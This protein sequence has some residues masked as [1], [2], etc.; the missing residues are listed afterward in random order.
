MALV[1]D[2]K[3]YKALPENKR[4]LYLL[5][6]LQRL[7]GVIKNTTRVSDMAG[8]FTIV[9]HGHEQ[10][11]ISSCQIQIYVNCKPQYFFGNF[12]KVVYVLICI[13]DDQ[14]LL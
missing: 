6:W 2:D 7:P 1:F 4:S 9:G 13:I 10:C 14:G 11:S 8:V 12:P 3:Q 5:Q